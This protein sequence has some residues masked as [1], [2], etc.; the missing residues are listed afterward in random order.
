[1][2]NEIENLKRQISAVQEIDGWYPLIFDL[3]K[4]IDSCPFSSELKA[5]YLKAFYSGTHELMNQTTFD[6]NELFETVEEFKQII[7]SSIRD[8]LIELSEQIRE[9]PAGKMESLATSIHGLKRKKIL[10]SLEGEKLSEWEE[11]LLN[12][13]SN[14]IETFKTISTLK[15]L[16]IKTKNEA[17]NRTYHGEETQFEGFSKNRW[18]LVLWY[19]SNG[20]GIGAKNYYRDDYKKW[21]DPLHRTK[22]DPETKKGM[23]DKIGHY[24]WAINHI[25][26]PV[27]KL[28]AIN[29]LEDLEK[30]LIEIKSR[31]K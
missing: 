15:P 20:L 25:K 26:D 17:K 24:Q 11:I 27:R 10:E 3:L 31:K 19:E 8:N 12:F 1:M 14:E 5:T 29:V 22:I 2:D 6:K 30:Q 9:N 21:D 18:A 28:E 16:I 23:K 13:L 7:K 4:F